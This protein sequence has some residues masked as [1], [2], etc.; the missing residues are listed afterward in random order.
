MGKEV[1]VVDIFTIY[2][3]IMNFGFSLP[4]WLFQL[5]IIYNLCNRV[6]GVRE[7]RKKYAFRSLVLMIAVFRLMPNN[8][9]DIKLLIIVLGAIWLFRGGLAQKVCTAE[10]GALVWIYCLGVAAVLRNVTGL[11]PQTHIGFQVLTCFLGNILIKIIIKRIGDACLEE[12]FE[13]DGWLFVCVSVVNY[14]IMGIMDDSIVADLNGMLSWIVVVGMLVLENIFLYVYYERNILKKKQLKVATEFQKKNELEQLHYQRLEEVQSEFRSLAH[15]MNHYLNA[16][17]NMKEEKMSGM[18][19]ELAEQIRVKI[20]ETSRNIYCLR[21]VLNAILNEK[22]VDA[23]ENGIS[24]EVFVEPG[25]DIENLDDYSMIGIMSNLID[26]AIEAAGKLE[27]K[28]RIQIH[29][30]AV[31]D[32]K[33]KFIRI[34]NSMIYEPV[35]KTKGFF[36]KKENKKQHGLGLKNVQKLVE[37]NRGILRLQAEE[38]RFVAEVVF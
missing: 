24:F 28:R 15:D 23:R 14:L 2:N 37:S 31:N 3:F 7:E 17:S 18:Q 21:P 9:N 30:F 33:Q 34:E 12:D 5:A 1:C 8:T 36:T 16:L 22:E 25:F 10:L 27:D 4:I 35:K 13:K 29:L 32:G 38:G 6:L 11:E 19:Y 26:N 20:Q